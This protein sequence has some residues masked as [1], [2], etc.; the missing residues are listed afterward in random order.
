M[1][2]TYGKAY[3]GTYRVEFNIKV[4]KVFKLTNEKR[5]HYNLQS[6]VPPLPVNHTININYLQL[7]VLNSLMNS[8]PF[9]K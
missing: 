3:R 1:F 5:D 4:P 2:S 8:D 9:I 7:N 6:N